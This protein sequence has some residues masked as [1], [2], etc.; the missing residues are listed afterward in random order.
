MVAYWALNLCKNCIKTP[1]TL[2]DTITAS[3]NLLYSPLVS[4]VLEFTRISYVTKV[5]NS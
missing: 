2:G 1:F 5:T 3:K 4:K